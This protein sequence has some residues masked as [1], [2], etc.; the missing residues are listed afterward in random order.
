MSGVAGKVGELGYK[1]F[2][3]RDFESEKL[4]AEDES[5]SATK[6][7]S[8]EADDPG[9]KEEVETEAT[10][11]TETETEGDGEK[12]S[13]EPPAEESAE[14]KPNTTYRVYDQERQFPDWAKPLVKSKEAED[15]F[16]DLLS[17]AD[18]LDEMKPRHQQTVQ[19]RDQLKSELTY[20]KDDIKR[21]V[22][23]RQGNPDLFFAELGVDDNMVIAAA[24][25]IVNA[26]ETP[27]DWDRYVDT[28]R[29]AVD[30]YN[31][32]KQAQGMSSQAQQQYASA[33]GAVFE[34]AMG[35]PEI[36]GFEQRFDQL[37]GIGAFRQQVLAYGN[38]QFQATK[39]NVSPMDAVNHVYEFHKKGFPAETTAGGQV[40]PAGK[41][42]RRVA[43]A[44][45]PN[46]GKGKNASPTQSRPRRLADLR[47]YVNEKVDSGE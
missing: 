8:K 27:E 9:E 47:K 6:E 40:A 26:K 14:Y 45:L 33:H 16:R 5:S 28:R 42:G 22:G 43:P 44:A 11:S 30:A 39:Q 18:G 34:M 38:Y 21:I 24:K 37:H 1:E 17:K 25:R 15:S 32:Q 46:V 41:P 4:G 3:S 13:E 19:E 29:A 20:V 10:E 36:K 12:K 35:H 2:D 31:A 7:E 23:L